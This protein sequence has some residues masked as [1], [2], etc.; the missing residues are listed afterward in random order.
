MR[1]ISTFMQEM[2]E[3]SSMIS[4]ATRN[5]F[6]VI[7]EL[8]RGTSTSEGYGLAKV[9]LRFLL[10]GNCRVHRSASALFHA[11]RNAFPRDDELG[12]ANTEY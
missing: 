6:L 10:L 11:F 1:G 5:S 12:G 2:L 4:I 9:F 3:T 8:G 7:D